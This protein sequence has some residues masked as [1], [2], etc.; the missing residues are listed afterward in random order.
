MPHK[1][2]R[3]LSSDEMTGLQYSQNG[4]ITHKWL[5]TDVL[6]HYGGDGATYA[7]QSYTE[8]LFGDAC[9]YP[10]WAN[11]DG[12]LGSGTFGKIVSNGTYWDISCHENT[13]AQA[14]DV[15]D[16]S[17]T[18]SYN[19]RAKVASKPNAATI[20]ITNTNNYTDETSGYTGY[21]NS[22]DGWREEDSTA[23][24]KYYPDTKYIAMIKTISTSGISI[25]ETEISAS[26][27]DNDDLV[28]TDVSANY[29]PD[30]VSSNYM[31]Q[32]HGDEL[33]GIFNRIALY[34]TPALGMIG[35]AILTKGP[36]LK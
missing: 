28:R 11:A 14:G 19:I 18:T 6:G 36:S 13:N 26:S 21:V 16:I 4:Y 7:N 33:Y 25:V 15:I 23:G 1:G 34:K 10:H 30:I 29:D 3:D 20:R 32:F 12:T 2:I 9:S 17:G 27:I 8:F 35:K 24:T 5:H 22:A 31:H